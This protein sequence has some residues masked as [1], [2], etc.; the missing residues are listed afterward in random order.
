[1]DITM[2][3]PLFTFSNRCDFTQV[4]TGVHLTRTGDALGSVVHFQPLGDPA[5]QAADGEHDGEH[6]RRDAHGAVDDA[7]VEVDVRVELAGDEVLVLQRDVLDLLGDVE[8]RVG[9]APAC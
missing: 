8:Q 2:K 9:D 4:R 7:A 3:N 1:M 6:V 5:R